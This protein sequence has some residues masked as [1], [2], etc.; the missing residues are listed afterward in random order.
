MPA[1]GEERVEGPDLEAGEGNIE[2]PARL[3][4]SHQSNRDDAYLVEWTHED[5]DDPH[6]WST[7]YRSWLTFLLGMLA[8]S[9]SSASAIIAPANLTIARYL[10]VSQEV[11][12][13]NISLYVYV[14]S[15]LLHFLNR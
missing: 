4:Q 12:T 1:A 6:N 2:T 8:L 14:Y 10:G 7:P 15:Q 13:L 5:K 3:V 9:A 11:V